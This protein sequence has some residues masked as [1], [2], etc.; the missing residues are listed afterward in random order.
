MRNQLFAALLALV[1]LPA[2]VPSVSSDGLDH[3][4]DGVTS[5]IATGNGIANTIWRPDAN[6][7][8][9]AFVTLYSNASG[10]WQITAM[11]ATLR[12]FVGGDATVEPN[13]DLVDVSADPVVSVSAGWVDRV[14]IPFRSSAG[15]LVAVKFPASAIHGAIPGPRL[16]DVFVTFSS[17]GGDPVPTSHFN[18]VRNVLIDRNQLDAADGLDY[19]GTQ[20]PVATGV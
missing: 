11:N 13:V 18:V 7:D 12:V 15:G 10:A 14:S 2:I 5:R 20:Y 3:G 1:A 4:P 9:V 6:G 19:N 17:L 16:I 8:Y